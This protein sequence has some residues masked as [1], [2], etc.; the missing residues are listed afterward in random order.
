[1]RYSLLS[2]MAF[3]IFTSCGSSKSTSTIKEENRVLEMQN[4]IENK[5][6]VLQT[7][8]GEQIPKQ[9]K[10][11]YI[12]FKNT[13]AFDGFAGCNR[14][15]GHYKMDLKTI[16]LTDVIATKMAC[17]SL[18]IETKL[19]DVLQKTNDYKIIQDHLLLMNGKDEIAKFD[20]VYLK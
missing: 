7:L 6:W 9:T 15:S 18:E 20:A 16:S 14:I 17:P 12:T 13:S 3:S 10:D 5:R 2:A 19:L 8:N 4:A 1:M 11:I